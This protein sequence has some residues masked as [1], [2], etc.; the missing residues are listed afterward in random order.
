[1]VAKIRLELED[2]TAA[3]FQS[4][5]KNADK[6]GDS[7][8]D[9]KKQ[10]E[11][12]GDQIDDLADSQ[13]AA[14][15]DRLAQSMNQTQAAASLLASGMSQA[16]VAALG[17]NERLELAEAAYQLANAAA[18]HYTD[19]LID[20]EKELRATAE[21][22]YRAAAAA[23]DAAHGIDRTGDEAVQTADQLKRMDAALESTGR[24]G[25]SFIE[26]MAKLWALK[27]TFTKLAQGA[28]Y[29]AEQGNP[30]F[31]ELRENAQE[32]LAKLIELTELEEIQ[33]FIKTVADGFGA[34]AEFISDNAQVLD[35][36]IKGYK[37][38]VEVVVSYL[39]Y[40]GI[41]AEGTT[42][43]LRRMKELE[44][45]ESKR[46]AQ[47]LEQEK[48]AIQA[49]KQR[50]EV[51][52]ILHETERAN[53]AAAETDAAKKI[54]S[55]EEINRLR[56]EE[57]AKMKELADAGKLSEEAAQDSQRR[58]SLYD[59]RRAEIEKTALDKTTREK[60]DA[61]KKAEELSKKEAD[62]SKKQAESA[63][64]AA[65]SANDAK[66][67][68]FEA[69]VSKLQSVIDS[70]KQQEQGPAINDQFKEA[71]SGK[72]LL[73]EVVSK[74]QTEAEQN[75][76]EQAIGEGRDTD[77]KDFQ[78]ELAKMRKQVER[79]TVKQARSGEIDP[80]E[81]AKAQEGLA[82]K[83]IEQGE[84]SG[85]LGKNAAA[86][87]K[88]QAKAIAKQN[89]EMEQ[90]SQDLEEVKNFMQQIDN[91]GERRKAQRRT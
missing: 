78:R 89:A 73:R 91:M 71:I 38:L 65:K 9:L 16:E 68:D 15:S 79:D 40:M 67:K 90:V 86:A 70:T 39:E 87:L 11:K 20:V 13:S 48:L 54:E 88:E 63:A 84:K 51:E 61:A 55:I 57:V 19:T 12:L 62:E 66:L 74:R 36:L 25:G 42:E 72:N 32:L 17:M 75:L 35:D 60:E 49:E 56:S 31:V 80:E 59:Q 41:V 29:L 28:N 22:E 83:I 33:T 21:A 4:V 50:A 3:G 77:G 47:K 6:A 7:L 8:D 24:S 52:K 45:E 37:D 14:A 18:A 30:A 82:G 26:T 10:F 69:Y 64:A 43:E 46:Y 2:A 58:I 76:R 34:A 85:T 27:E 81:F 1:M 5:E 23:G 53:A 44:E